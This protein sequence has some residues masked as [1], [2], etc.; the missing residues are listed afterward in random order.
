MYRKGFWTVEEDRVLTEHI[1]VHGKGSWNRIAKMTGLKRCG[2]SCRL[3]W[4]NYLSPGVKRDD[5]S[6]E[7]D[8]LIIRLHKLLGNRWSL[9]AGRVP[10]RTD[11]QVKNHWNTHLCKRLGIK[12]GKTKANANSKTTSVTSTEKSSET[13]LRDDNF[14]ATNQRAIEQGCF[15]TQEVTVNYDDYESSD[16]FSGDDFSLSTPSLMELLDQYFP[17]FVSNH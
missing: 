12:K 1:R 9:I 16:W 5:F 8:D 6:E 11:N 17:G 13:P 7:E 3:R 10:G 14:G 15:D 4:V 2:K